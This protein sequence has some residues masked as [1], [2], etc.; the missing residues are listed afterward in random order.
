MQFN[1]TKRQ[2]LERSDNSRKGSIDAPILALVNTINE[3]PNYV[4]TSSCSGRIMLFRTSS[5]DKINT[6]WIYVSHKKVMEDIY[7][8]LQGEKNL[9]L[10]YE[11]AILHVKCSSLE[12]AEKFLVLAKGVGFKRTGIISLRRR[13]VIE[14]TSSEHIS[15]P[16]VINSELQAN[17]EQ[18][19]RFVEKCNEFME[20]NHGKIDKLNQLLSSKPQIATRDTNNTPNKTHETKE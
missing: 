7:D 1:N 13:P 5:F 11:G 20:K 16:I 12:S 14:M 2:I 15:I 8:K 3:N 9:W 18:F 4:T 19:C 10:I 17:R 6:K